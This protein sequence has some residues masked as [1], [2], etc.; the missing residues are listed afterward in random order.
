[1]HT[2]YLYMYVY[3][4]YKY[5][6][7]MVITLS[8]V[9]CLQLLCYLLVLPFC[10]Q[11]PIYMYFKTTYMYTFIHHNYNQQVKYWLV[12]LCLSVNVDFI[13]LNGNIFIILVFISSR[14]HQCW[15]D[16]D[17]RRTN[18]MIHRTACIHTPTAFAIP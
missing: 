17:P 6:H 12:S 13:A 18:P 14:S 16:R 5:I 11:K 10:V 3:F 2:V 8:N 7:V 15:A 9:M 1:M 4:E